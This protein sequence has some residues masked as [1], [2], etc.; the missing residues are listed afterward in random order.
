MSPASMNTSSTFATRRRERG[1]GRYSDHRQTADRTL[2]TTQLSQRLRD[3]RIKCGHLTYFIPLNKQR[4]LITVSVIADEIRKEDLKRECQDIMAC[5]KWTNQHAKKLFTILAYV[6][7][8][9]AWIYRLSKDG[10]C[11]KDLPLEL[12][13]VGTRPV[14]L[15]RKSDKTILS[16]FSTWESDDLED[17]VRVQWWVLVP[18]FDKRTLKCQNLLEETV[19][20]LIGTNC[21]ET[22]KDVL[23]Q[24]KVAGFSTVTAF[25]IHS[26]HHNFWS[27]ASIPEVH[28]IEC[29]F[30]HS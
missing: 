29:R 21:G 2:P 23:P 8:G 22:S 26:A 5:A 9:G 20:P 1:H 6:K 13:E 17:F 15:R 10:I 27:L 25:R 16:A 12:E 11:D 7:K 3:A 18:R 24:M 28:M 19:M 30:R 4:E 14:T